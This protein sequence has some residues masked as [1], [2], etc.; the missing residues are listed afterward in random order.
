M[1]LINRY[2]TITSI[3]VVAFMELGV[4]GSGDGVM[5]GKWMTRRDAIQAQRLAFIVMAHLREFIQLFPESNY[6]AIVMS[7]GGQICCP[8][9]L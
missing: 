4:D 3:K 7:V 1:M 8:R 9:N 5:K 2:Q 6:L